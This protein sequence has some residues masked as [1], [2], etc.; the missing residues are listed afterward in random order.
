MIMAI[1][2]IN[3]PK[4]VIS[5]IGLILRDVIP[6][7]A[8]PNRTFTEYFDSPAITADVT[9]GFPGETEEEFE[10]SVNFAKEIG[11]AKAHVFA[12]SRR[13]GTM[14]YN[15]PNQVTKAEKSKRS[16]LMIKATA[17]TE[18]EFIKSHLGKTVEVLAETKDE[19]GVCTGYTANYTPVKIPSDCDIHGI[20]KTE[21]T[22]VDGDFCIG[23]I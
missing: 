18:A 6:S 22:A 11:F 17:E 2:N 14:A 1:R 13:A 15:M 16:H 10:N 5:R 7:V 20:T 9:A 23:K 21:I 19:N 12:Y 4:K 8:N 3:A